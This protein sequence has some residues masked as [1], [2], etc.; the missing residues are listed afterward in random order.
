MDFK[1]ISNL[2]RFKDI[3]VILLKYGFD[4]IL[5]RLEPPG[6]GILKKI[7]HTDRHLGTYERIRC[8]LEDLGPTF[9]KFG[10]VMSLRPD[11]LPQQ[12]LQELSKLQD[13]VPPVSFEE[14][15]QVVEKSLTRPIPEVFTIFDPDALAGASLSQVHRAVL[16]QEGHIVAVKVQRP[17]IR[18]KVETDLDILTAIAHR[19]HERSEDLRMYD[20]PNLVQVIRRNLLRELDFMREARYMKIARAHL[21]AQEGVYVPQVY[22]GYCTERLLVMELIQGARLKEVDISQLPDP[23]ALAKHGFRAAMKQVFEDGFFHADPHPGNLLI[24]DE[25]GLC[26]LDWGLVGRLTETDM[27]EL[28]DLVRAVIEKDTRSLV[29]ALSLMAAGEKEIDRRRLERELLD[30]L[31]SYHALPIKELDLGRL[32]LDITDLIRQHRLRLPADLVV[33]VKALITAEGTAREIY[34]DLN[35]I[36]EAEGYVKHLTSKRLSPEALLRSLRSSVSYF[37]ALQRQLPRRF[38]QITEKL[39]RGEL[40]IRF[41]HENLGSLRNTLDNIFSRLT[42]GIII[43]AMIIGSSMIITTGLG[44][45]LFGFPALGIIGYLISALLGLWV[46]FNIIRTR[47]Y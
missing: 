37:L 39:D 5:E 33:M 19:L 31:D 9:V 20:L 18:Q 26:L 38:S 44:P 40:R 8:A 45:F 17:N 42:L 32:L 12:L 14:I 46:I 11:L 10:Q 21:Y 2:G 13:E 3:V 25:K 24:S 23:E 22:E 43:A 6:A 28:T 34:P 47:K 35:V 15:R 1:T 27:R 7:Y 36:R 30:I 16:R 4:D 29:D 41:E